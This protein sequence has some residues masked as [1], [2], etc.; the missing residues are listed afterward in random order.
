MN[1]AESDFPRLIQSAEADGEFLSLCSL[2]DDPD[3]RI[4]SAVEERLRQRGT[5]M[6]H[7]LLDFIDLS[8]DDLAKHA[9]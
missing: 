3:V 7:P 6:L 4:A 9:Q 1:T 5:S 8:A 2:L